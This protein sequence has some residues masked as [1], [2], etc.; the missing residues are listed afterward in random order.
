MF[1]NH[2]KCWLASNVSSAVFGFYKR[3]SP[4]TSIDCISADNDSLLL[5]YVIIS[6]IIH[7]MAEFACWHRQF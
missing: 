1:L 4:Q 3:P 6:T 2:E 5:T 7:W